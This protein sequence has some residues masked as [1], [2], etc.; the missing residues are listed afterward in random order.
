MWRHDFFVHA[1]GDVHVTY[2]CLSSRGKLTR[3][4]VCHRTVKMAPVYQLKIKYDQD[5]FGRGLRC[6]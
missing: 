6:I 3:L 2:M 5:K 1:L 4:F